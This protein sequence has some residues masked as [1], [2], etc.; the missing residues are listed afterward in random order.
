MICR[1]KGTPFANPRDSARKE[2]KSA[3]IARVAKLGFCWRCFTLFQFVPICFNKRNLQT[4][5]A[6]RPDYCGALCDPGAAKEA[7]MFRLSKRQPTV[8]EAIAC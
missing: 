2:W 7:G 4:L 5:A 8:H 1:E 6:L 3:Q